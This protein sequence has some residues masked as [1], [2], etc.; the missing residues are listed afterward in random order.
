VPANDGLMMM[1]DSMVLPHSS[2]RKVLPEQYKMKAQNE[3]FLKEAEQ[4]ESEDC[5]T[6]SK[7]FSVTGNRTPVSRVTGRD[8]SHYTMTEADA[9]LVV[10]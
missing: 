2:K 6:K 1:I 4:N 10:K 7:K 3:P 5:E 8:T 9:R